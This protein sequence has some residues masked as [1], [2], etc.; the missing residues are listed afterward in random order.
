MPAALYSDLRNHEH[1][2]KAK[3]MIATRN[4]LFIKEPTALKRGG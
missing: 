3:T 1:K 2:F 4:N